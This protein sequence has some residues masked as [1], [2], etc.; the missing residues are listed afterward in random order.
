MAALAEQKDVF[1]IL[2][3]CPDIDADLKDEDGFTPLRVATCLD[4]TA[5]T[6]QDR[7][8]SSIVA[9]TP[10]ENSVGENST[11]N[12]GNAAA[13]KSLPSNTL[14]HAVIRKGQVTVHS[15]PKTIKIEA[16]LSSLSLA[17][18][19]TPLHD[20]AKSGYDD[21]TKA[22]L[23]RKDI[24]TTVSDG[25][26]MTPLHKAAKY[27]NLSVVKLLLER[28]EISG[29]ERSNEKSGRLPIHMAAKYDRLKVVA[30][31]LAQDEDLV[32][33]VDNDG[34]SVLHHVLFEDT[35]QTIEAL[36]KLKNVK[37]DLKDKSRKDAALGR[38]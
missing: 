19:R 23:A 28:P 14:D 11:E 27:G 8:D 24:N 10:Q 30:Y 3:A 9:G 38:D 21:V 1:R 25:A 13:K 22:L 34:K 20:A 15:S 2:L 5:R 32:N 12:A 33:A 4:T 6:V 29:H 18:G 7:I 31:Y 36:L 17:T 35:P 16:S 26:G 37:P